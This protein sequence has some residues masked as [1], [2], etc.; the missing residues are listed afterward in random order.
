MVTLIDVD[1]RHGF[2]GCDHLIGSADH[3]RVCALIGTQYRSLGE[4]RRAADR[5]YTRE[6]DRR[7]RTAPVTVSVRLASG[8][9]RS[10]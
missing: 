4:A 6:C 5:A 10:G 3:A 2:T 9:E 7:V 1:I 8:V